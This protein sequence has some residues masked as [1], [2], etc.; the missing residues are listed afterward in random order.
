MQHE[1]G[2]QMTTASPREVTP[3]PC[4]DDPVTLP[5]GALSTSQL[6]ARAMGAALLPD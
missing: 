4:F 2:R 6:L 1:T 5:S 3:R